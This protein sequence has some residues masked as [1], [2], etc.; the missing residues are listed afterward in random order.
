MSTRSSSVSVVEPHPT[1]PKG[2]Y[3]GGGRGGAGNF[4]RYKPEDLTPGPTATGPSSRITLPKPFKRQNA[5][6]TGRGGSGNLFKVPAD[7]E[8]V[9]QFDEEMVKSRESRAPVYHIGRGGAGNWND[10]REGS[11]QR[12]STRQDSSA[13]S[14]S[15]HSDDSDG[16]NQVRAALARISRRFS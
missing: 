5:L 16:S 13:S 3:I 4:K 6:L 2:G 10:E 12:K 15:T 9:F 8:R 7:E 11:S 1:V 14:D